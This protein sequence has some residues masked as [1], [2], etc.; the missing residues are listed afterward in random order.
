MTRSPGV[1]ALLAAVFALAAATLVLHPRAAVP[2]VVLCALL[3]AARYTRVALVLLVVLM[4]ATL[5]G[6][7]VDAVPPGPWGGQR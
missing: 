3:H 1:A 5:V 2:A 6:V 7:R 4:I